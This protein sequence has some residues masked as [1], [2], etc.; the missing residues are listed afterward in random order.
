[1]MAGEGYDYRQ[2]LSHYFSG[3]SI[4]KRY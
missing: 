1:M 4:E 3:A 2:I